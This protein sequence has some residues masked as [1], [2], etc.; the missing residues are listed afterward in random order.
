M[1]WKLCCK[2]D[3]S[4]NFKQLSVSDELVSAAACNRGQWSSTRYPGQGL[5]QGSDADSV[6]RCASQQDDGPVS[7]AQLPLPHALLPSLTAAA[8]SKR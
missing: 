2:K 8:W 5:N 3:N 1:F 6:D 7:P 4:C